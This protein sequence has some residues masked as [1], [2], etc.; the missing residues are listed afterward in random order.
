MATRPKG[1]PVGDIA[2]ALIQNQWNNYSGIFKD[3][4]KPQ[5]K[6]GP[7]ALRVKDYP[8]L[9]NTLL[10]N[11]TGVEP[12]GS[13]PSGLDYKEIR[14]FADEHEITRTV[15]ETCKDQL[16][17]LRWT[18]RRIPK[19]GETIE[20]V[21]KASEND[22][23]VLFLNKFFESPDQEHEFEQW[24]R[25]L[26]E[27]LLVCDTVCI[28]NHEDI[29]DK[30]YALRIIDTATIKRLIDDI[31]VTPLPP[32]VAYQQIIDGE[33]AEEFTTDEMIYYIRNP[34]AWAFHGYSPVEQVILTLATGMRRMAMQLHH[35]TDGNIPAMFL[36]AP[37]EWTLAQ[38]Q[39]FQNYWN[40]LLTG[41][42]GEL[43][44]GWMIPGDVEPIFPQKD[45]L[46]DDFDEWIARVVC[47]AFSVSPNAFIKNLNRATSEQAREQA[48]EEGLQTRMRLVTSILNKIQRKWFGFRD[49]EFHL[50][51]DR[52]QDSKKQAEIDNLDIRNG[53]KSVDEVRRERGYPAIGA[54]NRVYT[55]NGYIPLTEGDKG[56]FD[57]FQ[58]KLIRNE[59]DN[60][61]PDKKP[62]NTD[63][64]TDGGELEN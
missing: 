46:K 64:T 62:T 37:K 17:K 19:P 60:T 43:A 18:W 24:L 9:Y 8:A 34:R 61:D 7:S 25:I 58:Q 2:N 42:Y 49:V 40:E 33:V 63:A 32:E 14:R 38:I 4:G 16:C 27:E 30:P 10:G 31:G 1:I 5:Q 35:Y 59:S 54:P 26:I 13:D 50:I 21:R 22:A 47:Y 3:P 15:L 52:P 44:K 29:S 36:R 57:M 41:N 51:V 48:D 12:N 53:V 20:E 39:E 28:Y 23:R 6:R 11:P 55:N 56:N 45:N